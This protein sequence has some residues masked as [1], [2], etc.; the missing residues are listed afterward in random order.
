MI[1]FLE[2]LNLGN[3]SSVMVFSIF[4]SLASIGSTIYFMRKTLRLRETNKKLYSERS[5]VRIN[6]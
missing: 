1:F 3:V 2:Y 6:Q 5:K 4:V